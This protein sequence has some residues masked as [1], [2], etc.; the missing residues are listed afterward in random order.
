MTHESIHEWIL[1][2][3]T[4]HGMKLIMIHDSQYLRIDSALHSRDKSRQESA[5][6]SF[7]NQTKFRPDPK[8]LSYLM[9]ANYCV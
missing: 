3:I 6:Y 9:C 1:Y 8:G 5:I 2:Y 7:P 4:I